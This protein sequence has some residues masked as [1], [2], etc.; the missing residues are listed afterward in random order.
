[1]RPLSIYVDGFAGYASPQEVDLSGQ[2]LIALVGSNGSGKS[3]LLEAIPFA[4]YGRT[5]AGD[6]DAVIFQHAELC[7][8]ALTLEVSGGVYRVCRKRKRAGSST[9]TLER[10]LDDGSRQAVGAQRIAETEAMIEQLVGMDYE[11]FCSTV[12]AG[13][14]RAAGFAEA[15]PSERKAILSNLLGLD[16]YEELRGL[17]VRRG[18]EA[19]SRRDSL[20]ARAEEAREKLEPLDEARG[21]LE[22]EVAALE[23]ARTEMDRLNLE[24]SALIEAD[25]SRR[26]D[27][28][29]KESL[30]AEIA[31][32]EHSLKELIS[33]TER[34]VEAWRARVAERDRQIGDLKEAL[35]AAEDA[36]RSHVDAEALVLEQRARLDELDERLN[37]A[38]DE[39]QKVGAERSAADETRKQA[40]ERIRVATERLELVDREGSS[41]YVCQQ[42]LESDLRRRLIT[43]LSEEREFASTA[44]RQAKLAFDRLSQVRDDLLAE[45]RRL[46]DER[47][48][49]AD[50]LAAA[51][52]KAASLRA[53]AEGAGGIR[54]A[55]SRLEDGAGLATALAR[56][57]AELERAQAGD[58]RLAALREELR[59]LE[60]RLAGPSTSSTEALSEAR[61]E[62]Q[63]AISQR[64]RSIALLEDR[65]ST[66]STIEA[67]IE[68]Y[69]SDARTAD[70]EVEEYSK[71]ARAFGKDGIPALILEGV[72]LELQ[73]HVNDVLAKLSNG[74]MRCRFALARERKTGGQRDVLDILLTDS[75]GE[76][77][78]EVYSGG[79]QFRNNIALRVG[80]VRLL[81]SRSEAARSRTLVIDEGYGALDAEGIQAMIESLTLLSE[82]FDAIITVTHTPEIAEGFP[83]RL[84]VEK[85]PDGSLA[86][87]AA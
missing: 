34:S 11:L 42:S 26:A 44:E 81:A 82:D 6:L 29:R 39:G 13:Q 87:L 53:R 37:I 71:L 21:L 25:A 61:E 23:V 49:A 48:A 5:R 33:T 63:R 7:E 85:T 54:E 77:L 18:Q 41:C 27:L 75:V 43:E 1:M 62:V 2:R 30:L 38:V 66:Y 52:R 36:A 68:R 47:A 40:A 65:L 59:A 12:F 4:L 3:S 32:K 46:K 57:E 73:R 72:L 45:H 31:D 60:T 79:E 9:L 8:V 83:A 19:A 51:E 74:K 86:R 84:I 17:A 64:E 16:R 50:A 67:D 28:Q 80:L 15:R 14:G 58:D 20:L 35:R 24:I 10:V 55:L 76:R 69:R 22:G 56:A 70:K 78:Y